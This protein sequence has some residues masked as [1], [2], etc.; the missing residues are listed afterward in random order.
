MGTRNNIIATPVL[1]DDK[2]F[3]SVGQDP[4]HG[5][6]PGHL[7]AI[8]ATKR[9]DI[10]STGAIWHN[11]GILRSMSTAAVHDGILYHCDLSGIFRAIDVK[12]GETLWED[13]L[14]AAVWSS[15]MVVDGKIYMGDEDGD[16]VVYQAG[17]T[18]K[19]LFE[20]N[21]ENS[22]YTTSVAANGVLYVANRHRLYAIAE[23]A[24]SDVQ[25]VK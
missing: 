18:K 3:I 21:M 6:G 7:Y 20:T 12:T 24:S 9:G 19:I 11:D 2:V 4:E 5:E 17:R 16:V 13:D 8:D 14:L 1:Y 25:D 10:T 22:V 15:P 23:G